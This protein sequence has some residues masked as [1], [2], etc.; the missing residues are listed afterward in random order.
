MKSSKSPIE[1][2]IDPVP[3][4]YIG[5]ATRDN[6]M[7]QVRTKLFGN[8]I[9]RDQKIKWSRVTL[10]FKGTA[11]FN[12]EAR[13]STL[14]PDLVNS[15]YEL[16][17]SNSS[18]THLKTT[19]TL[20]DVEKE[21][22]YNHEDAIDFGFYLPPYLP[23]N[24]KTNHSSVEYTLSVTCSTSGTFPRTVM[25][26]DDVTVCRHYLP[27]PSCLIPSVEHHGA[28]EWFEWSADIPKATP[29]EAGEIVI[30]LRWSVE[31]EAVEVDRV[32]FWIEELETYR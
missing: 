4:C 18:T 26:E 15:Q 20:C 7:S 32:E 8:V 5:P 29:I 27:S 25:I 21:L 1:L 16:R 9:F 10:H 19:V 28:R 31:K 14:P 2:E 30:G 12:M 17:K 6:P 22:I 24:I 11:S 3:V 13:T 23:P